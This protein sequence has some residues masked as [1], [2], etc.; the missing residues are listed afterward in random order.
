[1]GLLQPSMFLSAQKFSMNWQSVV[2]R[3][4]LLQP[5]E[6]SFAPVHPKS[7]RSIFC[8][9]LVFRCSSE[10]QVHFLRHKPY[11]SRQNL[12]QQTGQKQQRLVTT[13]QIQFGLFAKL[14]VQRRQLS[15]TFLDTASWEAFLQNCQARRCKRLPHPKCDGV[16]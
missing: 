4:P 6:G 5:P 13:Y 15:Q 16:E 9:K 14:Q 10:K 12:G 8:T 7:E 1:M 3:A 2:V 11:W